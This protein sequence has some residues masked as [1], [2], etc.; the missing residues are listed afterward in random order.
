MKILFEDDDKSPISIL[1]MASSAGKDMIFCSGYRGIQRA[2]EDALLID[3]LVIVYIDVS[4]NNKYTFEMYRSIRNIAKES[5]KVI[6]IPIICA[7]YTLLRMLVRYGYLYDICRKDDGLRNFV[8]D[9]IINLGNSRTDTEASLEK[10]CKSVIRR[11]L[12]R[13]LQNKQSR[14]GKF[15]CKDCDCTECDLLDSGCSDKLSVKAER[16]YTSL[17]LFVVPDEVDFSEITKACGLSY[18][19]TSV[20]KAFEEIN[21]F[22]DRLRDMFGINKRFIGE[23]EKF[24]AGMEIG[25]E[26]E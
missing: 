9:Y 24:I 15:M 22:Y 18:K 13:C 7:E 4:P 12:P 1:L 23:K 17:P 10:M 20:E 16:M 8:E 11:H 6:V 2:I 5:Y 21:E 3:D 25:S 14:S 19:Q 26:I